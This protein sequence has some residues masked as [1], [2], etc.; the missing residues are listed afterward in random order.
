LA[1][2]LVGAG[3]GPAAAIPSL[4]LEIQGGF[5]D[6]TTQTVIATSDSFRLYAYLIPAA[7]SLLTDTYFISAAIIPQTGP[8][9]AALGSF[10]FNGTTVNVTGDMVYGV[11]PIESLQSFDAGDLAR[12]GIYET[13]FSEFAFHFDPGNRANA[14][15]TAEL[16]GQGPTSSPD[17]TMYFAAFDV[18]TAGLANG[19]A[20]HFD[21]YNELFVTS[22][23]CTGTGQNRTCTSTLTGDI[24]ANTFAPFSHDAQG[25]PSRRVPEPPSLVLAGLGLVTVGLAMRKPRLR[26]G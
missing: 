9:S 7:G 13:Y 2:A 22:R 19:Y 25:P 16:P 18:N 20:I 12:H 4:Q 8:A 3:A 15:N 24:D 10:V 23:V 26:R 6:P 14:Y 17:G 11:P 1:L 21:L 5:Y